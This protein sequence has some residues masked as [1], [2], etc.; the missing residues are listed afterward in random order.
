MK[1]V[2]LIT[3][4]SPQKQ[5]ELY[6][7][8]LVT[9]ILSVGLGIFGAWFIVPKIFLYCSL[10]KEITQ[11]RDKISNYTNDISSKDVLKRE[12]DELRIRENK[13]N[14]YKQQKKNPYVHIAEIVD[15]AGTTLELESIKINK[16]EIEIDVVSSE[17]EYV[18]TFIKNIASSPHFSQIKMF[19]LQ[20]DR[21]N[22]KVRCTIKGN[23]VF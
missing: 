16:K 23:I 3:T 13:I 6:R 21:E 18:Q 2:N 22:K 9:M 5:Y 17:K 11:L 7:W 14:F 15:K 19:S 1:K 20:Q 4:V 10:K 8:F 12:Y